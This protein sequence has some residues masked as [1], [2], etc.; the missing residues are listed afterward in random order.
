MVRMQCY[1]V[2]DENFCTGGYISLCN[3]NN[4]LA[5]SKRYGELT[6]TPEHTFSS[7]Q[8]HSYKS[9]PCPSLRDSSARTQWSARQ[10]PL[11]EWNN[12]A[13]RCWWCR[14]KSYWIPIESYSSRTSKWF[15]SETA[16]RTF[17]VIYGLLA[18]VLSHSS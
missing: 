6:C 7:L 14:V 12:K 9:A 18:Q 1:T 16:D 15:S 5:S 3:N 2:F 10:V 13:P 17:L 8:L 11:S 4:L